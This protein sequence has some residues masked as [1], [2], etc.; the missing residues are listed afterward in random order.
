MKFL[1]SLKIIDLI[2]SILCISLFFYN[3]QI[4]ASYEYGLGQLIE[5]IFRLPVVLVLLISM[6]MSIIA[7]CNKKRVYL[8]SMLSQILKIVA[9]LLNFLISIF[10]L[11][12]RF[13]LDYM[14]VI[15]IYA[16]IVLIILL[17]LLKK[18]NFKMKL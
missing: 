11:E 16:T 15:P 7:L 8:F 1:K 18:E 17:I 5:L 9:F 10:I 3:Y 14:I 13:K 4:T 12:V 6:I 2:I